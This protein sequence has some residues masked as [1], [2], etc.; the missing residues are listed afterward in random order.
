MMAAS[1]SEDFRER[2]L[3]AYSPL[4]RWYG[5]EGINAPLGD[6]RFYPDDALESLAREYRRG[7]EDVRDGLAERAQPDLGNGQ[8][9]ANL[10][11]IGREQGVT[12]ALAEGYG[13]VD[14]LH[15]HGTDCYSTWHASRHGIPVPDGSGAPEGAVPVASE[16]DGAPLRP[17]YKLA[18]WLDHENAFSGWLRVLLW[19]G[20]PGEW[21]WA[22][23]AWR[24]EVASYAALAHV[25]GVPD[26][27]FGGCGGNARA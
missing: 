4:D 14:R 12:E 20:A 17:T 15:P 5:V 16:A 21:R 26:G 8:V 11:E 27:V 23:A 18:L 22:R 6:P 24:E 1:A 10:R 7:L 13:A 9:E 19:P 3:S 2:E 25:S